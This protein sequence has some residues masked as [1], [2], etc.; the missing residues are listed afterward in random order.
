M[1]YHTQQ[2]L[3]KAYNVCKAFRFFPEI[4]LLASTR[5][6]QVNSYCSQFPDPNAVACDAFSLNWRN[7][8]CWINPPWSLIPAVLSK[9]SNERCSALM[10][11]PLWR[12]APW[13]SKFSSLCHSHLILKGSLYVDD[14][15]L[16]RPPPSW[17][18]C[19]GFILF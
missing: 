7:L 1:F 3:C 6:H 4:D 12:S 14:N 17:L 8:R 10:L 16:L 15:G 19:V 9:I 11:I 2:L 5:H 18:S 13:F